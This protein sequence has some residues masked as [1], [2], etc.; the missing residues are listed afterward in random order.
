[1][2]EAHPSLA[3]RRMPFSFCEV[4]SLPEAGRLRAERRTI[5]EFGLSRHRRFVSGRQTSAA[6]DV[7]RRWTV[8]ISR[9]ARVTSE[10]IQPE[11]LI[12]SRSKMG[13]G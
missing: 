3:L 6:A 13:R 8:R 9:H 11:T 2:I 10:C 4:G 12:R 7:N 1:M 5:T